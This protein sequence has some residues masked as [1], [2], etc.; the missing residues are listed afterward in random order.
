MIWY[1]HVYQLQFRASRQT[2]RFLLDLPAK[3]DSYKN[4]RLFISRWV[5]CRLSK[6]SFYGEIANRSELAW[7][8]LGRTFGD[9]KTSPTVPGIFLSSRTIIIG[10]SGKQS[11]LSTWKRRKFQIF[12]PY[13]IVGNRRSAIGS[14]LSIGLQNP[15]ERRFKTYLLPWHN[16]GRHLE[17][18]EKIDQ[19][20]ASIPNLYKL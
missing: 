2:L 15:V 5:C 8:T 17:I 4:S 7:A 16:V 18:G 6:S 20:S 13:H 11:R 12:A 3:A 14:N 9:S 1:C 10:S 19:E